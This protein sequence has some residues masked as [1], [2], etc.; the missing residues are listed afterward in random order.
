MSGPLNG[1]RVLD[2]SSVIMGPYATAILGDLGADV[3]KVELAD[4]DIG[5]QLGP[6]RH[7]GMSALS[8][9]LLRNKR[10]IVLDPRSADGRAELQQLIK[11]ADA[12]VTNLRPGSR[13]RL[14]L[15][16]PTVHE[17]N[18]RVVLC[19][20]QA[21][22]SNSS[23]GSAPAYD[24]VVQA[25]SGTVDIYRRAWGEPRFSPSV[26]ADK[27]CGLFIVN[28]VLAALYHVRSGGP[29]QWVDVP[30]A[31]TMLAFNLVEHL[32]GR[33]FIPPEGDLGWQR[34]L[35]PE[36]APHRAKDGWVCVMPYSDRNWTDFFNDLGR[37]DLVADPRF[38]TAPQRHT[39]SGPLQAALAE[40]IETDTVHTWLD[41]CARLGI[42]AEEV[43]DLDHIEDN[44]YY[45]ERRLLRAVTHPSEGLHH[46]IR[47]PVDYSATPVPEPHPAPNLGADNGATWMPRGHDRGRTQPAGNSTSR[48]VRE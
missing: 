2:L 45:R 1:L 47:H 21:F 3:I 14:G 6:S 24:D 16:W 33:T 15:D 29:G 40:I 26:V 34:T 7:Q 8:L 12:I 37:H 31:D 43:L 22:A 23:R 25:I 20:A 19:T 11:G 28:S 18:P 36:R 39:H 30:M 27:V 13:A 17:L 42:A 48:G 9:N 35:V 44:P 38:A 5:R 4:G 32:S 46:H 10:S 41:M